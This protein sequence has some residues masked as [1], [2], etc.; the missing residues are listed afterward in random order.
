MRIVNHPQAGSLEGLSADLAAS[1]YDVDTLTA[2]YRCASKA[3]KEAMQDMREPLPE[4]DPEEPR[5]FIDN[6]PTTSELLDYKRL[7]AGKLPISYLRQL[8]NQLFLR[9]ECH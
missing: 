7:D 1:R 8:A 5:G 9:H 2:L 6:I 3:C 4:E